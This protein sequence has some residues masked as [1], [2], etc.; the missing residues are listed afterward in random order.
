MKLFLREIAQNLIDNWETSFLIQTFFGGP[1]RVL[2]SLS[3]IRKDCSNGRRQGT[4]Q[5]LQTYLIQLIWYIGSITNQNCTRIFIG[6][7]QKYRLFV[8]S[9]H[10]ASLISHGD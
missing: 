10:T 1:H 7:C 2:R 9:K 3:L 5:K 6:V 4:R 8:N